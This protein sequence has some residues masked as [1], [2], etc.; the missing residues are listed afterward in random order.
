M[1]KSH[2]GYVSGQCGRCIGN[3][4]AQCGLG[5]V[6]H[7]TIDSGGGET[8]FRH[9]ACHNVIGGVV[10][11]Y[12]YSGGD[13]TSLFIRIFVRIGRGARIVATTGGK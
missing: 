8:D 13:C 9:T 1:G 2:F 12:I 3:A 10:L 11:S 7:V 6:V 5:G 4:H